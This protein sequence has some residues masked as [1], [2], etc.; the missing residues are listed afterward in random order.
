MSKIYIKLLSDEALGY[1]YKNIDIVTKEIIKNDDNSWVYNSFPNPIFVE[2]KYR[3]ED[4]IIQENQ[5][6]D[7]EIDFENHKSV[8]NSLKILPRYILTN[9]RF[10]LWLYL[11]KFYK[12]TKTIMQ[13]N[14]IST[15]LDHWMFKQGKRRGVFFGVLS[16]M[17]FR[18]ELTEEND[19][20]SLTKWIIEKPE[21]FRNLTWRSYSSEKEVTNGII[22]GEKKAYDELGY[23]N[24]NIYP[25]I[26][27]YISFLG[28]AKILDAFS[29]EDIENITYNKCKELLQ[30]YKEQEDE[31]IC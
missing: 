13:I 31:T 2:K 6:E 3:I 26:A 23:E 7:F 27:K 19:D 17:Y 14:G 20:Y 25:E 29:R 11:E 5:N 30:Q 22:R 18:V 15:I 12:E 9:E 8:Y 10:W 16:R 24:T 1:M 21:R 4:F 28:S